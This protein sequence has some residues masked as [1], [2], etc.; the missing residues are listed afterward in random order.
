M[1]IYERTALWY[2]V[3]EGH[4]E[5][6]QQLCNKGAD[7]RAL[8]EYEYELLTPTLTRFRVNGKW[9]YIRRAKGAMLG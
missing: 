6:A 7:I 3:E 9:V 8:W 5:A 2:A 1:D 4:S